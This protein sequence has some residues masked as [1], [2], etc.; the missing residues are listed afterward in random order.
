MENFNKVSLE[1]IS[2][3]DLLLILKSLEFTYEQTGDAEYINLRKSI[4]SELSILADSDE[5]ELIK[6]LE[7]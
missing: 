7:S 4:V 3:K 2:R 1:E 6:R 5:R